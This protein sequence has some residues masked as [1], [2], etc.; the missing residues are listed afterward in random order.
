MQTSRQAFPCIGGKP[1][2]PLSIAEFEAMALER[3]KAAAAGRERARAEHARRMADNAIP[4]RFKGCAITD[5]RVREWLTGYLGGIRRN[6]VLKGPF[7]TG[8]TGNAYAL[9]RELADHGYTC[10]FGTMA[11]HAAF[12]NEGYGSRSDSTAD[13]RLGQL[14]GVDVLF[15]D[16]LG[17]ETPTE[18]T[19]EYLFRIVNRRSETM[20]P[21]VATTNNA[22]GDFLK[23]YG[24]KEGGAAVSRL[25]KEGTV[26]R[27]DGPDMRG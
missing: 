9:M 3:A 11:D 10:R 15:I 26:V 22:S 13:D 8:K 14:C 23:A 20:R 21:I 25:Y 24:E 18:R 7:G 27:F 19:G 1:F 17:K 5:G 4:E 6:L 16:D 2:A 12:V